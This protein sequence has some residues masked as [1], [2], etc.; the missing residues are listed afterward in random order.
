MSEA[1]TASVIGLGPMG[2]ATVKSL[3]KAGYEVTVWNRSTGKADAMV[4]L[5]AR[6]AS[7]VAEALDA[8]AVTLLSL[9]H[10]AAMYDVLSQV[11][12]AG[13]TII[14]LSSDSPEKA[15]AGAAW[16]TARGAAF[17]SAGYM[18]Q[19]DDISHPLSYLLVS[20]P[21][22]LVRVHEELLNALSPVH[23]VG[24]DYGFSQV[25][26][27]AGLTLLH[28]VM[29][30]FEQAL[31]MV[32]RSGGD[33]ERYVGY[34]VKFMDSMKEFLVQFAAAAKIGGVE[35]VAMLK[36]MDAGA[37]HIIDAS[38]EVGVDAT[39]SH[40]AQSMW[41]RAIDASDERG[42]IVSSYRL[43]RGD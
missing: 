2:Q 38:E 15:R 20:G 17:V 10:Y 39:L 25:Y 26:Y 37:Q 42:E 41:R 35:D 27:Q 4:E 29:L 1:Q 8:G 12:L 30:S 28:P 36:M 11:A 43:I 7:S 19:G 32:E 22:Q 31:A 33:T 13:K 5:G 6:K 40:A 3:L 14:N 23:Y 9:T 16:V 24:P 18:S 21:H 34:A